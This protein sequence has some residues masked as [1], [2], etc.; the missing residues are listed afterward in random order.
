MRT[1][2]YFTDEISQGIIVKEYVEPKMPFLVTS[3]RAFQ[4]FLSL[5]K[6]GLKLVKFGFE[7]VLFGAPLNLAL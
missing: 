4:S 2:K 3:N 7:L 1:A 6:I 5:H